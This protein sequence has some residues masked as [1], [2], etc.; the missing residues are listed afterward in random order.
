MPRAQTTTGGS[1]PRWRRFAAPLVILVLLGLAVS[2]LPRG[3][4][5]HLNKIG[6]GKFVVVEV[7]DKEEV[8]SEQL[9]D[10]INDIRSAYEARG[11]EFLLA[12]VGT[13]AGKR[14]AQRHG[15]AGAT[16]LVFGPH[17]RVLQT[18]VGRQDV[19]SLK[20]AIDKALQS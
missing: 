1:T 13:A 5:T 8:Q 2:L 9:M 11:V 19:A 17:G 3:Y 14:F 15:V 20:H 4:D 7:F 12:D 16:L 6:K 18:L 10:T